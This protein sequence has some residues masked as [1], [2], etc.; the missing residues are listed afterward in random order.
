MQFDITMQ[1]FTELHLRLGC[2]IYVL[3]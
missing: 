1:S 3:L 2:L